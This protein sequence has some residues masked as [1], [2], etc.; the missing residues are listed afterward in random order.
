MKTK[1]AMLMAAAS[2]GWFTAVNSTSAQTWTQTSAP[3]DLWASIASSADGTTLVAIT[4]VNKIYVSTNSG[5]AWTQTS[6]PTNIWQSVAL[7]ADGTKLI[8]AAYDCP[9]FTSSDSGITWAT[10]SMPATNWYSVTCSADGTRLVANNG[11]SIYMSTNSGATWFSNN[12]P[13]KYGTRFPILMAANG[14]KLFAYSSYD[15][16]IYSTTDWGITWVTNNTPFSGWSIFASSAN[17]TKLVA[18]ALGSPPYGAIY[19]STNSGASWHLDNAMAK[20]WNSIVSSADGTRLVANN[21]SSI[22]MS[23]NSGAT[24]ISNGVPKT[25][26]GMNLIATSAD[27]NKLVLVADKGGGI[28]TCQLTLSPQLNLTPTG[29][30]FVLSWVVPSTNFVLQHSS[31]LGSWT[32]VT[33]KPALNL[34]NLQNE[35]M[36]SPKGS[37]GFYR[38]KTP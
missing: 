18:I 14:T 12:V 35:V 30:N 8:A 9:I 37:S 17:G 11:S 4:M 16:V 20:S 29:D 28:W 3:N 5:T 24:W 34:T 23:T 2:C 36:L 21:G 32:D 26:E 1:I 6:A 22:Y 25:G 27:G 38:L 10:N 15:G 33:N 31:N 19:T 13:S 7:S